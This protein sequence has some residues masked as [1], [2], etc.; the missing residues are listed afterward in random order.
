VGDNSIL[1]ADSA[2]EA[3]PAT[4]LGDGG[5]NPTS[6]LHFNH[7]RNGNVGQRVEVCFQRQIRDRMIVTEP[8]TPLRSLVGARVE[9]ITTHEARPIIERYEWL[10]TMGR[11]AHCCGLF[12]DGILLGVACFGWPAGI[13]SRDICGRDR[14]HLAIA[15]ERGACVHW[16]PPNAASFL[17]SHACRLIA[18]Q[19]GYRIFYAYSDEDA[20]EMGTVYQACNW[21]YIGRGVGRTPGRLREYYVTPEGKVVSCRTLRHR[22]LRKA[23]ALAMGW[24]LRYQSPKHKYVWFEGS[25]VEKEELR[26]TLRYPPQLYPKRVIS[27]R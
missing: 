20:G 9:E 26:A 17:I 13:E 2:N 16:A 3:C 8:M 23:E 12:L 11:S 7:I 5:S 10:G 22:G 25:R 15:L 1:R 27:G 6:A 21:I 19:Y 24:Q 4:Q 18:R 14:R